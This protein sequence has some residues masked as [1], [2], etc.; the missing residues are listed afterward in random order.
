MERSKRLGT[1]SIPALLLTFSIPAIVGM[2]V[3]ALYNIVDRIY[4][5]KAMGHLGI[6]AITV[7]FPLFLLMLAF[8][9][10]VG[11]GATALVSIRLGEQKKDE[12]EQVLGNATILLVV[13]A[14][15]ITA[16]GLALLDPLLALSGAS[17]EVLP[18]ARDYARILLLGAVFQ[19]LS[20][21]LNAMIRGEGNPKIAMY[22]MLIGA[23]LNIILDPIFIFYFEMGVR[24]AAVATVLSQ[25]A[26]TAW[27]VYYFW[28]GN[29]LLKFRAANFRL[30]R[31]I[32]LL[33]VAI[34]SSPCA[35]QVAASV[36]NAILNNQLR[37]HG[38]DLAVSVIGIVWGVA[39]LFLMPI[40]GINQG[41]QPIIG[42][43]YGA[44]QFDRVKKTLLLAIGAAT[45]LTLLGFAVTMLFPRQ[46]IWLFSRQ[47][48]NWQDLV[49][50]GSHAMRICLLMLPIVGFQI[51]SASY[52]Q[53]IGKPR[54][55]MFLGLS[56]QVLLL[57]PAL[58]ILPHFFYLDG[59]WASIPVADFGSSLLTGVWLLFELRRLD[60]RHSENSASK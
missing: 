5:G 15:C 29:S 36:L 22:T 58:L 11:L 4:V 41:A 2:S 21:G 43:N 39:M 17:K 20:F 9:M 53:A 32:C 33:I 13:V 8:S 23:V 14:A 16:L 37:I 55:A 54:H 40:F 35:M 27:V 19:T 28:R 6:A 7:F 1:G 60:D 59:V 48:E 18:F 57:I 12:A 25:A 56:R 24:G 34:G 10:L 51:V 49:E 42:Y 50:L 38:G 44:R 47:D 31:R 45:T 3:H 46:V 26:S 52:F 30:R